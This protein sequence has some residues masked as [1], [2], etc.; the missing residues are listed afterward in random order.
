[1]ADAVSFTG[2]GR[3]DY[4]TLIALSLSSSVVSI[5]LRQ[6]EFTNRDQRHTLTTKHQECSKVLNCIHEIITSWK[7]ELRAPFSIVVK[8]IG[9]HHQC[10]EMSV[11]AVT[12][13][14]NALSYTTTHHLTVK[15]SV[16]ACNLVSAYKDWGFLN[17]N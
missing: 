8:Y 15:T 2:N 3:N 10:T 7:K 13:V 12:C 9:I 4:M 6:S 1:M 16:I 5:Y 17:Y 14:F 11:S